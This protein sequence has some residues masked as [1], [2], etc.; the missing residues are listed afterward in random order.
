MKCTNP[1]CIRFGYPLPIKAG[2]RC[3][4]CGKVVSP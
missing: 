1:E 2:N 3:P 4:N